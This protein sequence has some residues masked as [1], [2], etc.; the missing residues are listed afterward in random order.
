MHCGHFWRW[1]YS[2]RLRQL[3]HD[4]SDMLVV[5]ALYLCLWFMPLC[6]NV[7]IQS[8]TSRL[9]LA[10]SRVHSRDVY[11][12]T[13]GRTLANPHKAATPRWLCFLPHG[14]EWGSVHDEKESSH[15]SLAF[16]Y[17]PARMGMLNSDWPLCVC[18]C[19][20]LCVTVCVCVCGPLD[21][22]IR[23]YIVWYFPYF[24]LCWKYT[25]KDSLCNKYKTSSHLTC[26]MNKLYVS[27]AD[28]YLYS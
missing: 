23:A 27:V 24:P 8:H 10:W 2:G 6:S 12:F 22:C 14:A 5:V 11:I 18:D 17:L 3:F 25:M 9:Q 26:F 1:M 19:V 15:W 21:V 13:F 20:W 7:N 4:F 16:S 28:D